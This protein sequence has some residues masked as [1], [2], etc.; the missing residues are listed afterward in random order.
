MSRKAAPVLYVWLC[1]TYF[2]VASTRRLHIPECPSLTDRSCTYSLPSS[3]N[4]ICSVDRKS[5]TTIRHEVKK[6]AEQNLREIMERILARGVI[7]KSDAV[8]P[9][10]RNGTAFG[11]IPMKWRIVGGRVW[12]VIN[13]TVVSRSD[14][15][16]S[17]DYQ[18]LGLVAPAG[19]EPATQGL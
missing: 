14:G 5:D 4:S 19:F 6:P 13:D 11:H 8:T 16:G 9:A 10:A 18:R 1:H 12:S 7:P 3:P 17:P 2:R 15:E